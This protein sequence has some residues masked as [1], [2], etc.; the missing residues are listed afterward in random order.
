MAYV[1]R[2]IRLDKDEPFYIG[3]GSDSNYYRA[4]KKSQ[5]NIYWKRII[6]KTDYSVDILI[7]DLTWDEACNKEK[8]FIALYGRKDLNTGCLVNMTEGGDGGV[9]KIVSDETKQKLSIA[10]KEW[11]KTRVISDY[12]RQKAS[13]Q[14][15]KLNKDP[16]FQ[17]KRIES[18]RSSTKLKEYNDSRIGIP[19]GYKHTEEMKKKLSELKMGK[20]LQ[21]E[22]YSKKCKPLV[23]LTLD[24]QFVKQWESARQVQRETKYLQCNISNCCNGGYKQAYGF[25][26]EYIKQ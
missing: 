19:S 10:I 2:H 15:K 22:Q 21:F 9:G 13:N 8:E 26:W 18:L 3:I 23:Q 4:N 25:K 16:K 14:F 20:K 6:A 11:N 5:R 7:D 12:Q 1:Y 24:G 17:E